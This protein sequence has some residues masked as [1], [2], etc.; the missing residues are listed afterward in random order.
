MEIKNKMGQMQ[1]FCPKVY[2][3]SFYQFNDYPSKWFLK[4]L[5]WILFTSPCS[6]FSL[7]QVE[8]NINPGFNGQ[9]VSGYDY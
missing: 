4:L 8:L 2:K 9:K 7:K 3:V 5:K 6:N 1:I